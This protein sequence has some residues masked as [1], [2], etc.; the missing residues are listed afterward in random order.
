MT[1]DILARALELEEQ[2]KDNPNWLGFEAHEVPAHPSALAKLVYEGILYYGHRSRKYTH[3]RVN[4]DF[5]RETLDETALEIPDD[6]FDIIE[7]Y[8]DLKNILRLSLESSRPVHVLLYGPPATAKTLFLSELA[9]LDGARYALGGTSTRAG[10]VDFILESRPRFLIIDELE[11]M[12]S[13]DYSSLLSLMETGYVSRLH[14][15]AKESTKIRTWV[16]AGANNIN[17]LPQE[18]LSRFMRVHIKAYSEED[19]KRVAYSVLTKREGTDPEIA[20]YIINKLS[21]VTKDV[22]D[23]VRVARLARSMDEVDSI[24]AVTRDSHGYFS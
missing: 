11:K 19:F 23:A 24:L 3:Y 4:R 5:I 2:N 20:G 16:F 12:D 13:R 15:S 6:L 10:I 7:G 21:G 17:K 9:R 8:D 14:K 22:R 18:L 1:Q